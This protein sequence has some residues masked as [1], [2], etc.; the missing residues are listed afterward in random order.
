M[1]DT[2]EGLPPAT[3]ADPD[4]EIAKLYT[5]D[6][7][8]DMSEV[9]TLFNRLDILIAKQACQ[10]IV[11]RYASDIAMLKQSPSSIL[12]ETGMKA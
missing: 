5:G 12:T 6:C 11:S 1:F 2:F 4:Y 9:T 8:G 10:G 3:S 7:R